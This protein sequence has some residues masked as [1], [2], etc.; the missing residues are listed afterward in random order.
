MKTKQIRMR[1]APH[2][3]LSKHSQNCWFCFLCMC[4]P[5]AACYINILH[6][7]ATAFT[8]NS[9]VSHLTYWAVL[10]S[11]NLRRVTIVSNELR[12]DYEIDSIVGLLLSLFLLLFLLYASLA[13]IRCSGAVPV[14]VHTLA[15][16]CIAIKF[17]SLIY[18]MTLLL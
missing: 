18:N 4:L 14:F 3:T 15:M 1:T 8:N 2:S 11:R 12:F 9:T 16:H 7:Q 10:G 5:F 17:C 6:L 13:S